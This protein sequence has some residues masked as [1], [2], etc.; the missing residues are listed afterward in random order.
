VLFRSSGGQKAKDVDVAFY[1][2]GTLLET[3]RLAELAANGATATPTISWEV[4]T[5][6]QVELKV[7]ADPNLAITE[8]SEENN[9]LAETVTCLRSD[10][11]VDPTIL[12]KVGGVQKTS[13]VEE[14]AVVI[15]VVVKNTGTYAL[16]QKDV[17]VR[18]T[19]QTTSEVM[20]Q[21]IASLLTGSSGEVKV[22]F[23]WAAKKKGTHTF[24]VKVN[25]D[26]AIRE[27]SSDNNE[28]TGTIKVTAKAAEA[29]PMNMALIG[30]AI[31]AVALVAILAAVFMLRKKPAAAPPARK[32]A[33]AEAP[34]EE[35]PAVEEA[36]A[37][38]VPA[39]EEAAAEEAPAEEE[40]PAGEAPAEEKPAEEKP[41]KKAAK[42]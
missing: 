8:I 20:T 3:K 37:E 21:T 2:G 42:K 12:F 36:A 27:K 39:A 31:G 38:E 23:T 32:A 10:L 33:R 40:A 28:A 11:T 9:E 35:A 4:T 26:G 16:D 30:G 41:R 25:P 17:V 22:T 19:D 18:L 5:E 14:T 29:P 15:E 7:V 34:E 6:G 24:S 1:A 13:V